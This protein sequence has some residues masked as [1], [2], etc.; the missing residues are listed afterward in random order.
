MFSNTLI[1][2]LLGKQWTRHQT[3]C[4]REFRSKVTIYKKWKK[5][6]TTNLLMLLL[7]LSLKEAS[8]PTHKSLCHPIFLGIIIWKVFSRVAKIAEIRA[9]SENCFL[10][11][12][13]LLISKSL[14]KEKKEGFGLRADSI[15]ENDDQWNIAKCSYPMETQNS[16]ISPSL[17][18]FPKCP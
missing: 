15:R 8:Y 17:N 6:W 16:L 5:A 10:G 18:K 9:S 7:M 12:K 4:L 14:T 13:T 2:I 11:N 1:L 3:L